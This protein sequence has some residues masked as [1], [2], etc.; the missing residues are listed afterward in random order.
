MSVAAFIS[1][2]E[3]LPDEQ[4]LKNTFVQ[5][6][7]QPASVLE[8]ETLE[9]KNWCQD[10][11]RLA[12]K[13]SEAAV[14]LANAH[15][16]MVLVGIEDEDLR[17]SKFSRCPYANVR[18]DWLMQRIHDNTV[19]P[20]EISV[21]D[22]S[23][24][25]EDVIGAPANCFAV[26]VPK[27]RKVG[28]HQTVGGLSKIR[29]GNE[30]RPYYVASEDDRTKAP[31][32]TAA[33]SDLA[34]DSVEWGMIQHQRKFGVP[35]ERWESPYD[36]LMH[37]GLI[38]AYLPDEEYSPRYRVSLAG[39]LLFGKES[40]LQQYCP[41]SETVVVSP[42]G[43]SRVR[44]NIS[45]TFK[46]LCGSRTA[47]LS[48]LCPA[49][50]I[51]TI[52]ELVA[53][54][55]IHRS[56]R[57]HAPIVIRVLD[58]NLEIESPGSLPAGLNPESLIHC[59]PIYRNFLLAEGARYIG[60]CDKIGRGIDAIYEQVLMGGFSF[61]TFEDRENCFTA[62]IPLEGNKNFSEFI[63]RRSQALTQ[64]DDIIV[65]RYLLEH[66]N[67]SQ[68]ELCSAMQRS[69]NFGHTILTEMFRKQMIEPIDG[70][71]LQWRLTPVVRNDIDQIFQ[72][73]QYNFGFESLFG[74]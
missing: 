32:P 49:I 14:C 61:P 69:L 40:V 28:G 66:E 1:R 23:G 3:R 17:G 41:A 58:S 45:E 67:A 13:V 5:L 24:L 73:D 43:T 46:L 42:Q 62:R 21:H 55:L 56:Y 2:A 36:F 19:P 11:K 72:A 54:A 4:L 33:P 63:R 7:H 74:E 52:R 18:P 38:E 30:C 16:G 26:I 37:V 12:E 35:K 20:V 27:T 51:Q 29:S 50:P 8:S 10:E 44:K 65:L 9:I 31:V 6:C 25:L 68:K 57:D 48:S 70:M 64:L 59:T 71:R 60:L 39:L 34:A 47:V 53:N 22:V 15:G